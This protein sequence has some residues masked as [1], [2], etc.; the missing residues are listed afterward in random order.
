MNSKKNRLQ[1]IF[2]T[3]SYKKGLIFST[4][5]NIVAK[6]IGF[7]NTLVIT[8]F[9]G[10]NITTDIYFYILSVSL[11]I[12]NTINNIDQSILIP[13]FMK[14]RQQKSEKAAQ[15]FINFFIYAYL[16]M[17]AI[18]FLFALFA[19]VYFYT[20]FSKF[21][22]NM[23]NSNKELLYMGSL[24]ILFQLVNYLLSAVLVS[25]KL[26]SIT[27]IS[28]L[29]N[30]VFSILFTF[31]FQSKLGITGTMLG[32]AL[33]YC[34]NFFILLFLLKRYQG[35][36]FTAI[37]W[38]RDMQ[39]WKNIGLMQVNILPVWVR[40]YF[41]L[42]F[43][44]GLSMGIVTS[45]NL[46][47]MLATLPEIFILSQVASI[48]GIKFSELS[49]TKNHEAVNDLLQNVIK[50]LCLLI[51]PVTLIMITANNEI[52]Q[53][54]FERGNF[55]KNS[56]EITA[57]CFFYLSL[58]MPPKI[59]DIIFSRLFTSFQLYNI[60]ILYATIAHS[61]ITI[62]LFLLVTQFTLQGYFISLLIGNYIILP[63]TFMLI[64][65]AKMKMINAKKI[66]FD[67]LKLISAGVVVYFIAA[68]FINLL[69][70]NIYVRVLCTTFFVISLFYLLAYYFVDCTYQK[71]LLAA[72]FKKLSK[73]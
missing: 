65:N 60:T 71:Q 59:F 22:V 9:F 5:L 28:G 3:E 51:F 10:S 57:Y 69:P 49:V 23:L 26:F 36:D 64:I 15:E 45:F 4:S 70:A 66:I 17:G 54:A 11:L 33:G 25:S 67:T 63:I 58:L 20:F 31:F 39:V 42:Y 73:K 32:I 68:L 62:L 34:I 46:A 16:L 6:A 12:T 8:F 21:N 48:A 7:L 38:M 53:F 41:V 55:K 29:I 61:I 35:W 40:N 19:P 18:M 44:T 56:V 50:T 37:K 30:S 72:L 2:K 52:I 27:I 43:L 14:L 13:Q 24:I 1:G 47:Q